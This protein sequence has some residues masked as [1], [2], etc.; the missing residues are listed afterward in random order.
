MRRGALIVSVAVIL[1]LISSLSFYG[2]FPVQVTESVPVLTSK[3]VV[4]NSLGETVFLFAFV[5][6][7]KNAVYVKI[8]IPMNVSYSNTSKEFPI[9]VGLFSKNGSSVTLEKAGYKDP[10]NGLYVIFLKPLSYSYKVP[11]FFPN[12]TPNFHN[13]QTISYSFLG[14]SYWVGIDIGLNETAYS[15]YV[16]SVSIVYSYMR[17]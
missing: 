13:L 17:W 7:P 1:V 14:K 5:T 11:T 16:Q 4:T 15:I 9:L 10:D 8:E 6:I 3:F 2:F 12:G